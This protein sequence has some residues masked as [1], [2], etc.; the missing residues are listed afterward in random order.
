MAEAGID[1]D[2]DVRIV[3]APPAR[4]AERLGSGAIDGFCV[5]AP[6]NAQ[7]VADGSGE[8]MLYAS[9]LWRVGPDKVFGVTD[10]WARR[11]PETLT[12]L[13]RALIRAQ[14]WADEPG[15]R[16]ELAALLSHPR[17]VNAPEALVGLSLLGSP[18]YA[19]S[20][21]GSDSLDYIIYHR[22]AASFPWRS[23]AVWFLTQ[24]LRWGQIGPEVDIAAA[25]EA[26]YRPDL[27]RL[28]AADLGA[29]APLV[30]EK[31]EGLH[32]SPW[33]LDEATS[34]IAMAPDLF[35]DGG[36]FDAAQ[37]LA[38]AAG[39]DIGRFRR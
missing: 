17:Y 23:H 20:E 27:Y 34:P 38:Y 8:I 25:A 5:S 29:P 3:V 35:F 15:H 22:Y 16:G 26:A 37:P 6:W 28:A 19:R 1:P 10:A 21:P 24:M 12:A 39:F 4:M 33:T 13:L 9:D 18:P 36:R 31:V 11:N 2:R 32:A 14:A 30:D 7:A